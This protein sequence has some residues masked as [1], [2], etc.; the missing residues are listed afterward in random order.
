MDTF[1]KVA[2][3]IFYHLAAYW[4]ITNVSEKGRWAFDTSALRMSFANPGVILV[5]LTCLI[6][7]VYDL[8]NTF[9]KP[10][11]YTNKMLWAVALLSPFYFFLHSPAYAFLFAA[12]F[13]MSTL[14]TNW[15]LREKALET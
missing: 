14:F 13:A 10:S 2:K 9:S 6:I 7:V 12:A 3:R 1:K 5:V 8:L 15:L 4:L 11:H